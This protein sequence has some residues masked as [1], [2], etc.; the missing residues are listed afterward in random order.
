MYEQCCNDGDY[1]SQTRREQ[2]VHDLAFETIF[3]AQYQ[4]QYETPQQQETMIAALY[5]RYSSRCLVR[6]QSIG[7]KDQ[8][9]TAVELCLTNNNK[10]RKLITIA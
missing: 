5:Q 8:W 3:E 1:Q 7:L 6:A 2:Y 4:H 9:E 10:E